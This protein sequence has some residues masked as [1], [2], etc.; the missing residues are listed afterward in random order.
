MQ[1]GRFTS[2]PN[3]CSSHGYKFRKGAFGEK[4][5]CCESILEMIFKPQEKCIEIE[6]YVPLLFDK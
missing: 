2:G 1:S 3:P 6:K 4:K 5:C